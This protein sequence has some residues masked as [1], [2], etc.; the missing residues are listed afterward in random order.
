MDKYI[1][2]VKKILEKEIGEK[3]NVAKP[4][5]P[6]F[7]DFSVPC[8]TFAGKMGKNPEK[9]ASELKD[10]I[11]KP[12]YI[13]KVETKGPY[14]NFFIKRDVLVDD[15]IKEAISKGESYGKVGSG[16]EL[17]LVESP[18]PNTNKPLHLGHLRNIVLG[19]SIT[20]ILKNQG[21]DV[22]IVNVVNDRG[23]HICKSMLAYMK[24]GNG[25]T[26]E[27][28]KVKSDHFVGDYYV[29]YSQEEKN[30]P[31]IE[32]E[33]QELLIKWEKGDKKVLDLWKKMNKW[34]MGG[35]EETYKRLGFSVEREYLES[36]TY[37]HGRE[38]VLKGLKEGIFEKDEEGNIVADLGDMGK[39][40]LL[41][42]NGTSVYITQDIYLAKKRYDEFSFNR[43]IYVVGSEQEHHFRVLFAIF[44]KLG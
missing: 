32:K 40:V 18:G 11:K 30:S 1:D 9:I 25:K 20:N 34:A 14:I 17:I 33:A 29:K 4:P 39:K 44:K 8:F 38:I 23:I 21:K 26:P 7:G 27:S 41:R 15:I 43:T 28:E 5:S 12:S 3:V 35:F 13:L 19:T 37:S 6:D 2:G 31:D 42:A 22:H 24:S 36:E 10:K 16:K